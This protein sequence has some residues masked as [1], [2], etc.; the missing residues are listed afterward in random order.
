MHNPLLLRVD[1]VS[2]TVC[3]DAI[4]GSGSFHRRGMQRVGPFCPV[5]IHEFSAHVTVALVHEE[6][7]GVRPESRKRASGAVLRGLF[8]GYEFP[9]AHDLITYFRFRLTKSRRC[10]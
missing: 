3:E 2:A 8:R 9:R 10:A 5:G 7:F 4:R 6:A 1:L